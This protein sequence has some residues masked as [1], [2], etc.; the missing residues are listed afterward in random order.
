MNIA[1]CVKM[2]N[3][4]F[5]PEFNFPENFVKAWT[6]ECGDFCLR[7]GWQDFQMQ[8]DGE[9]IAS[10]IDYELQKKYIILNDKNIL[11]PPPDLHSLDKGE[12]FII[13][14]QNP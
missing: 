4:H 5:T 14:G 11:E 8:N 6:N 12:K 3:K 10:G 13:E 1:D 9:W 2:I 7:I